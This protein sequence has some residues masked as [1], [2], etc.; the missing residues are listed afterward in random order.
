MSKVEAEHSTC[1]RLL[2]DKEREKKCAQ[3][4]E[5]FLS[6]QKGTREGW[7]EYSRWGK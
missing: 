1:A 7:S 5:G 4:E 3:E 6:T 2:D